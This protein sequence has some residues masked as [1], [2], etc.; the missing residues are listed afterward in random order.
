MNAPTS[1]S[2][3]I[4]ILH[5]DRVCVKCKYNLIG[6]PIRR[7]TELDL[8]AVQCPECGT[9][10]ALQ[11]YPML[12]PWAR[13]WTFLLAAIW[14]I[15]LLGALFI[16]AGMIVGVSTSTT[17]AAVKPYA[18]FLADRQSEWLRE[19]DNTGGGTQ[20]WQFYRNNNPLYVPLH[21]NWWSKQDGQVLLNQMGGWWNAIDA[22]ACWQWGSFAVSVLPAGMFWSIALLHIRKRW[23]ALVALLIIAVAAGITVLGQNVDSMAFQY[24]IRNVATNQVGRPVLYVSVALAFI[25]LMIGL[26]I[27]RP[28]VRFAVRVLLPPR[29]RSALAILW[30]A[31]GRTP[32]R[33]AFWEQ[34]IA[35]KSVQNTQ[36]DP[37]TSASP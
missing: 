35:E 7:H 36:M 14:I 2:T 4:D 31:E 37:N 16:S 25:P 9:Y 23:F 28:V 15:V 6:Q 33:R 12:G 20:N 11:E 8:L 1:D 32:P 34:P 29:L 26:L 27:G 3:I 18:Q 21:Q 24:H 17:E 30:T 13:R 5:G 10:A 19:Q 22:R